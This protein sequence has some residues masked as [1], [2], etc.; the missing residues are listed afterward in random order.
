MATQQ[1][2]E[3]LRISSADRI[4]IAGMP[5]QG[6]TWLLRWMCTLAEPNLIIV[7]PLNQYGAFGDCQYIPRQ[8]TP[9]ELE[10]IAKRLHHVENMTLVVEEA[11]QF[12]PQT[13]P[14]LPWTSSLARMG[15]NWGIGM[16]CSTRSIQ[17]INKRFFDLCQH[18]FFFN[19]GMYSRDYIAHMVGKEFMWETKTPRFNKS[20]YTLPTLPPHHFFDFDLVNQTAVVRTLTISGKRQSVR[21]IS[22][23]MDAGN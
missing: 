11:E 18:A 15:R 2:L 10:Q 20:G 12:I 14:M 9:A 7:D 6:K 5:G 8:E 13:R 21:A 16:W 4:L 17:E 22:K 23:K 19:C 3:P 1:N